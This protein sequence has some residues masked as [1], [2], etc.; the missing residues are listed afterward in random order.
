MGT[1]ATLFPRINNKPS[2]LIFLFN[3][4]IFIL[5]I[6]LNIPMV[7]QRQYHSVSWI[8]MNEHVRFFFQ[9]HLYQ[10]EIQKKIRISET[11]LKI[12]AISMLVT[13]VG[14]GCWW[15]MLE[16]KC[17]NMN[18]I[19]FF[20]T[21]GTNIRKMSII[22]KFCHQHPKIFTEIKSLTS[23]CHH[24]LCSQNFRTKISEPNFKT[25]LL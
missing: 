5:F 4:I 9:I 19:P 7:G 20:L 10:T 18:N 15:R 14:D 1:D 25:K 8:N 21:L 13:D 22:A 3:L 23:T 17:S 2:I 11:G 12:S 6:W 16:T 24:H